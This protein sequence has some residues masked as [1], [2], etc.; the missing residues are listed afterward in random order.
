MIAV[1]SVVIAVVSILYYFYI[2]PPD[3]LEP[4]LWK[5][6]CKLNKLEKNTILKNTITFYE[7]SAD[8]FIPAPESFAFD[9]NTG[10]FT[11]SYHIKNI[12]IMPNIILG[13]A[14]A[15][16]ADGRVAQFLQNGSYVGIVL[17]TGGYVLYS[18]SNKI[19]DSSYNGI[20]GNEDLMKYCQVEAKAKRLAWNVTAEKLC[21]RPLGSR[22]IADRKNAHPILYIL[23]AYHGLFE[24]DL[25]SNVVK[26]HFDSN[27]EFWNF[28][29][30][31]LGYS[32]KTR[33]ATQRRTASI[34]ITYDYVKTDTTLL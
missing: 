14:F 24:I 12:Q 10:S 31:K 32:N 26:H 34:T 28:A 30:G 5:E 13:N 27:T 18:N 6:P 9:E 29:D 20:S 22:I 16:L 3:G 7:N 33:Y 15:T 17:F 23:D 8:V 1:Y 19:I 4:N 25:K 21:G 11:F 2:L